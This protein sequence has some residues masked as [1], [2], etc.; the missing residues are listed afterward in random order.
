MPTPDRKGH[1]G[2]EGTIYVSDDFDGTEAGILTATW[3][4][5]DNTRDMTV[6][7]ARE[8]IDDTAR[9]S[10]DNKIFDVGMRDISIDGTMRRDNTHTGYTAM[11]AAY[12]AAT[13]IGVAVLDG[14]ITVATTKGVIGLM[15][16]S[17]FNEPKPLA[18]KMDTSFAFKP[19]AAVLDDPPLTV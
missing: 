19:S 14:D 6:N 5:L 15:Y 12:L 18:G 7:D 2:F 3:T 9:D 13:T 16:P 1:R 8:E 17:A 10:A 11:K 4:A